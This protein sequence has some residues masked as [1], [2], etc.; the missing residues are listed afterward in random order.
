VGELIVGVDDSQGARQAVA[1]AAR[2]AVVRADALT[3]VNALD[4][5]D[6]VT[7]AAITG[8]A[9]LRLQQARTARAE[10]LLDDLARGLPGG[11]PAVHRE[12]LLGSAASALLTRAAGQ[13]GLIVGRR[14]RGGFA[15]LLLGSVSQQVAVH[16]TCPVIVVPHER[17]REPDG[18]VVVGVD[19]SQHAQRALLRAAEEAA[20]RAT[21]LDV[22]VVSPL[23]PAPLVEEVPLDADG[24]GVWAGTPGLAGLEL[25]RR[26][27]TEHARAAGEWQAEVGRAVEEDLR[28]L[29]GTTDF[30][31]H[32]V[33]GTHPAEALIAAAA[34][35]DLLVVGSRGYGGFSGM[36][37]G[38]VSQQC[39][40]HARVPVLVVP[41]G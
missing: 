20:L 5:A 40:R 33:A 9:R 16:A 26:L 30:K 11:I 27:R 6:A 19:G 39:V 12:V 4:D 35:A 28:R 2:E 29:P 13:S 10:A 32:L 1:W 18:T 37:V 8:A 23:L 17:D 22:I 24:D 15:G 31:V 38:S 14:G 34:A 3:L 25:S 7:G 36:L 41:P 21:H